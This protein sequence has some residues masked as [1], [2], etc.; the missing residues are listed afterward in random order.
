MSDISQSLNKKIQLKITGDEGSLLPDD[1]NQLQDALIH[2]LRNSM[3]HGIESPSVRL[4]KGKKEMGTIEISCEEYK[5]GSLRIIIKDD[6]SGIN[7]KKVEARA[8]ENDICTQK[9]LDIMSQKEKIG[10][11]F[12]PKFSTKDTVNE[13][14]GRGFG[15]DVVK[16]TL[17]K[18][19][20]NLDVA[21][22]EEEGTTFVIDIAPKKR[23]F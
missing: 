19:G 12:L 9:E 22:Q 20:A 11:I 7:F 3:D 23:S 18:I 8:L 4:E 5:T 10:L 13:I 6:G 1:F 15:M 17:E 2:I 16:S 14:S 21:T